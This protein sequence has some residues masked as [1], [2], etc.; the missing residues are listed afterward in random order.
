[1]TKKSQSSLQEKTTL[2]YFRSNFARI[3]RY[4]HVTWL[5]AHFDDEKIQFY[6]IVTKHDE[7][8][9]QLPQILPS[10]TAREELPN[11]FVL[12]SFSWKFFDFLCNLRLKK[13]Q[14][15]IFT[16][17][18]FN[19]ILYLTLTLYWLKFGGFLGGFIPLDKFCLR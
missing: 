12:D 11:F 9:D 2:S 18:V 6:F 15:I 14:K 4:N 1:M 10:L 13:F 17:K 3:A 16:R 8:M 7:K 5:R 19:L